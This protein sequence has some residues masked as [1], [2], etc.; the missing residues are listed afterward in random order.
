[1]SPRQ[2]EQPQQQVQARQGQQPQQVK[3]RQGEGPQQVPPH[4]L[5]C[6]TRRGK[7]NANA[8][9]EMHNGS[10]SLI[11]SLIRLIPPGT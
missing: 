3:A 1:M 11:D 6:L 9:C 7:G 2:G 4:Q 5:N 10:E 8:T